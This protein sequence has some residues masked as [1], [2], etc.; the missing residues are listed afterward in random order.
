MTVV[1][2]LTDGDRWGKAL[3]VEGVA[4]AKP[5]VKKSVMC[6]GAGDQRLKGL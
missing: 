3:Q 6:L 5:E 1:K 2:T 4:E